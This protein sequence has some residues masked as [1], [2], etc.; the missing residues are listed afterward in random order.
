MCWLLS[1]LQWQLNIFNSVLANIY[2]MEWIQIVRKHLDVEKVS[3]IF[4]LL[5]LNVYFEDV[6]HFIFWSIYQVT[7]FSTTVKE[8]RQKVNWV[9][10]LKNLVRL[11]K[12][13]GVQRVDLQPNGARLWL[14]SMPYKFER[15]ISSGYWK[16]IGDSGSLETA[17]NYCVIQIEPGHAWNR[18]TS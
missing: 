11:F 17:N 12:I 15:Q 9:T 14:I 18:A 4:K 3:A 5:L 13:R 6:I 1:I 7:Y 16:C 8:T 10:L 2:E